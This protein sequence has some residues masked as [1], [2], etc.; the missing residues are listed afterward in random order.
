M[1]ERNVATEVGELAAL[2]ERAKRA[3]ETTR[4]LAQ[5][6]RFMV[7]WYAMR[8]RSRLRPY[9]ILDLTDPNLAPPSDNPDESG[10]RNP[11]LGGWEAWK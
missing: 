8:A 4:R 3:S 5:E 10:G 2:V 6:Y 9:P 7:T 11:P 1:Q